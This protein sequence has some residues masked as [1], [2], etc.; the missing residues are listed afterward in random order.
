[1]ESHNTVFGSKRLFHQIKWFAHPYISIFCHDGHVTWLNSR[2]SLPALALCAIC[3]QL[4][5]SV[6]ENLAK[7]SCTECTGH[8]NYFELIPM[9]EME[10]RHHVEGSVGNEFLWIYNHCGV[11]A[12][13]SRK[14]L[15][16]GIFWVFLNDPLPLQ[17][18]VQKGFIVT[19]IEVLCS[20][21]VKFGW[22]K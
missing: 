10:M 15:K 13:W 22:R 5:S 1:V 11:M 21:F 9:V 14:T 18:S 6:A 19:P 2:S 20:N 12:A 17:N 8:V 7:V 16:N 3:H 4:I